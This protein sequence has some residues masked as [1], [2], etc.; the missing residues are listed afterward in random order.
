MVG[1]QGSY[2]RDKRANRQLHILSISISTV[3]NKSLLDSNLCPRPNEEVS[4]LVSV[5]ADFAVE[6]VVVVERVR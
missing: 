4:A 6:V 5:T 3:Y 1:V 2:Q